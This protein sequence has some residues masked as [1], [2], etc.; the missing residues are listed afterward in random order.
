MK[1]VKI[2]LISVLTLTAFSSSDA[3]A[4]NTKGSTTYCSDKEVGSIFK[5]KDKMYLVVDNK[6]ARDKANFAKLAKGDIRYC[7]SKV[8]N[9]NKMF[10]RTSFNHSISDWD[11]SNVTNMKLMFFKA[12]SF[13]Q[14]IN[15]W[16]TSNV[17]NMESMFSSA[18]SFNQPISD[19]NT[20]NV[21]NMESM[22]SS[23]TS[24]NQPIGNWNTSNV[25]NMFMMLGGATS[26]NQ[27]I[28]NWNT[29]NVTNIRSMFSDATS[30]NQPIGDWNTSYPPHKPHIQI[31]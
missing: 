29:F 5:H 7:T 2:T 14:P 30:F 19:W 22:F 16:N 10:S 23:A 20:S 26:F 28:G 24:F 27:P 25:T 6:T 3:M 9:M 4:I 15:D 31:S 18:T 11:T 13:N 17:T 21:T 8:T 1:V 12:T